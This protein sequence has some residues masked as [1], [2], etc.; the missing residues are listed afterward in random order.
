MQQ[1]VR[2]GIRNLAA[3]GAGLALAQ[4]VQAQGLVS[5][6]PGAVVLE[7]ILVKVNGDL[8]TQT[9]LEQAQISNLQAR[10]VS[11]QTDTELRQVLMDMTPEIIVNLV[12]ELV[13]VQ[14]G[15]ELGYALSDEQFEEILDGIKEENSMTDEELLVALGE[16]GMT[17]AGL[18]DA[19]E[20]QMLI[21][22][23]QQIEIL[24]RVSITDTEA[25]EYYDTHLEEFTAPATVT[26]REI[27]I[28]VPAEG[29][30]VDVALDDR[31]KAEAEAV[32]ARLLAGDDF[33]QVAADVSDAVSKANGGRIGPIEVMDLAE[34]VRD[35]IAALDVGSIGEIERTAAG[36]QILQLESAIRPTP[37]SFEDVRESIANNVFN[38]RRFRALDE[39]LN[40]LRDEAI[41]EWKDETLK[42]LYDEHLATRDILGRGV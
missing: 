18:R 12:E 33:G 11:P 14:R 36:Y 31:A 26:L 17:L 35:Q 23:V 16:Q 39:Y 3:L 42:T 21:Q 2:W 24:G 5:E 22:Q 8:V 15:R 29:G 27:L 9:N 38:E 41:I 4:P 1:R 13:M 40:R 34:T 28:G 10:G 19:T 6:A 7:R 20:R 25:R 30:A 37:S 32:R